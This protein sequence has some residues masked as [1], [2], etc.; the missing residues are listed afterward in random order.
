M[1]EHR[2]F[3]TDRERGRREWAQM[4]MEKGEKGRFR[5]EQN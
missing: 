5:R 4:E 1:A 3:G 2:G